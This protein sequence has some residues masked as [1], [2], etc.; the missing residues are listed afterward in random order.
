MNASADE[1]SA[2]VSHAFSITQPLHACA[3]A[4]ITWFFQE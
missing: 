1:L 4:G 2:G 3:A